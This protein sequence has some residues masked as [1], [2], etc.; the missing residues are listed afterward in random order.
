MHIELYQGRIANH[1]EAVDFAR[2]DDKD[3]ASRS[4]ETGA[5]DGPHA[6]TFADE[7]NL[8]IGMPMG[9]RSRSWLAII[10][11]HGN[12]GIALFG[13][14]KLMRTADMGRLSCLTWCMIPSFSLS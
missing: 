3:V 13:S 11:E 10:K 4:F 12:T 9:P 6:T 14:D 7:L 1:L 5:I 8:I 2:F